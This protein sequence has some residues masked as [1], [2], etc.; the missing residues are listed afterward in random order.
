MHKPI[1][2][3]LGLIL[4]L[5]AC[6]NDDDSSAPK[7]TLL[8][9]GKW[10]IVASKANISLAAGGT[11]EFDLL[12]F[13]STC[14]KDGHFVFQSAGVLISDE[15]TTKCDPDDPQQTT[16]TWE[17]T[18]NETYLKV[19]GTD[20]EFEGEIA[21]LTASKLVIKYDTDINGVPAKTE[22]E[23]MNF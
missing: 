10:K 21:E 22:T 14:E 2:C 6:K 8:T 16:G 13:L 1:F 3:L 19:S 12:A 7:A 20:L 17:L 5:G 23:F 15:G 9:N 11:T 18:Q 4:I